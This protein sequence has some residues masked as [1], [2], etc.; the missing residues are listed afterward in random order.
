MTNA[1]RGTGQAGA[2]FALLQRTLRRDGRVS[3]EPRQRLGSQLTVER[4]LPCLCSS[5]PVPVPSQCQSHPCLSSDGLW[6]VA[7]CLW[8]CAATA[9]EDDSARPRL[10]PNTSQ[11]GFLV[12]ARNTRSC[13]LS[14]R[15]TLPRVHY[16]L[17]E[18]LPSNDNQLGAACT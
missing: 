1:A 12:V 8:I 14:C 10:G 7:C 9:C 3:L 15:T 13:P 4:P 18:Y 11:R 17:L 6:P 2:P 5:C 16:A